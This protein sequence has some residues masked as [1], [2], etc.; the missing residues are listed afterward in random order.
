[1]KRAKKP[2][3]IEQQYQ[4]AA[5]VAA[6]ARDVAYL[7]GQGEAGKLGHVIEATGF[8]DNG[9]PDTSESLGAAIVA[10]AAVIGQDWL[11]DTAHAAAF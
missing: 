1:M 10:L 4:R 2:N 7:V 6:I 8:A 9:A 3:P 11:E 5:L